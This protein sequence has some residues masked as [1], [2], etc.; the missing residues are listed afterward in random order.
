MHRF[1]QGWN[2]RSQKAGQLRKAPRRLLT[3]CATRLSHEVLEDRRVLATLTVTSLSDADAAPDGDGTL[4]LR[5]AIAYVNG[6]AVETGDNLPALI[7]GVIGTPGVIDR[8]VFSDT[9]FDV[10]GK[11][12]IS[13][14]HTTPSPYTGYGLGLASDVVIDAGFGREVEISA[15]G[16]GAGVMLVEPSADDI[17]L[18]G[19]ALVDGEVENSGGGLLAEVEK[20]TLRSVRFANNTA[21]H[22]GGGLYFGGRELDAYDLEFSANTAEIQGGGAHISIISQEG[23]D[24]W[25]FAKSNFI[26]NESHGNGGGLSLSFNDLSNGTLKDI[27]F[28]SNS[29]ISTDSQAGLG[30]GAHIYNWNG[31]FLPYPTLGN[32]SIDSIIAKD[33]FASYGG[34]GI[35]LRVA[36]YEDG[37]GLVTLQ[38]CAV[39]NNTAGDGSYGN[40]AFGGGIYIYAKSAD[41]VIDRSSISHNTATPEENDNELG[42]FAASSG[43]GI[44]I[45]N[46]YDTVA[47][48]TV[49]ISSSTIA[50]NLAHD[51]GGLYLDDPDA[52]KIRHSTITL[53]TAGMAAGHT[54]LSTGGGIAMG[55]QSYVG[56][57]ASLEIDHS[58]VAGNIHNDNFPNVYPGDELLEVACYTPNIGVTPMPFWIWSPYEEVERRDDQAWGLVEL[59][60]SYL[61]DVGQ[62]SSFTLD[63]ILVSTNGAVAAGTLTEIA[64]HG[65]EGIGFTPGGGYFDA[66]DSSYTSTNRP[67]YFLKDGNPPMTADQR[68]IPYRRVYGSAID[69]GAIE[70]QTGCRVAGDYNNDGIVNAADYTVWRD[71]LGGTVTPYS[72]GDGNG[73]GVVDQDDYYI[74]AE[75]YGAQCGTSELAFDQFLPSDFN[76]DGVVDDDDLAIWLLNA[77]STT[78]LQADAN[79]DGVVDVDDYLLWSETQGSTPAAFVFEAYD[80][81]VGTIY[82]VASTLL[83]T[84]DGDYSY[85][86]LSLREAVQLANASGQPATILLREGA[87]ELTRTGT[88]TGIAYN[89]LDITGDVRIVGKGAGAS[90][91]DVSGL[92]GSDRFVFDVVSGGSL[93]VSRITL[94]NDSAGTGY[95]GIR[96]VTGGEV[97]VEESVL[98]GFQVSIASAGSAIHADGGAVTIRRSVV[99]GNESNP[100]YAGAVYVKGGATLTIG[101]SAFADNQSWDSRFGVWRLLSVEVDS[102]VTKINEGYNRYDSTL[103]GFFNTTPGTGDF[104]GTPNYVV[105]SIVDTFNHA[106]DNYA[107][108]VREA[109]DL[110]NVA[111]GA[112][113]IWLPAW[114]FT[115]TRDRQNYGGGSPTDTD[116][117]FGDIDIKG[118]LTIRGVSTKTSVAWKAGVVDAVFDLLGDYNDDGLVDVADYNIRT[119]QNGS[120]SGTSADWEIYSADG[121]DDGDVDSADNTVWATYYGSSLDLFDVDVL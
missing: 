9:L 13:L 21:G 40:I 19:L 23:D 89:D 97:L 10:N 115:L 87:Y 39:M 92:T 109:V 65:G 8:I 50:Y 43:G 84:V 60:Y 22:S 68:G 85:G 63:A 6:A 51:G 66:G 105:T 102:S 24:P 83:D 47:Y 42:Q 18:I 41:V 69:I 77:G 15:D 104:L 78:N 73:D 86:E 79:G 81:P 106:D 95:H 114:A 52:V 118:P 101:D 94:T 98:S 7:D 82:V 32:L 16:L 62:T 29:A 99:T 75:N 45:R 72:V 111:S 100:Y 11:A 119:L 59:N 54:G 2:V 14:Q 107:L 3:R 117:T 80:E 70:A 116:A 96:V 64:T 48:S 31:D 110:A 44:A 38:D 25:K 120:G 5:E 121:D 28:D 49:E 57:G 74:W 61:E 33:N 112:Q 46:P 37:A 88:E 30:G 67:T 71:S 17:T 58:I 56:Y 20:L 91:I 4:T 108:S 1:L 55:S 103:G 35:S 26:N 36:D 90:I 76:E 12:T 34:G 113:A 27:L 53:N 93:S